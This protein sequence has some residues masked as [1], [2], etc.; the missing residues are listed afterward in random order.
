[1]RTLPRR[2][3][4][5]LLAGLAGVTLVA[6][7]CGGGGG[8]ASTTIPVTTVKTT[9]P[10]PA[11]AQL[12]QIVVQQ[13]DLPSGWTARKASPSANQ[14]ADSAAFAQCVGVSN[15]AG[16]VVAVA[17][18]PDFVNGSSVIASTATSFKSPVDVQTDSAALTNPKASACFVQVVKARLTAALPKGA[19]VKSVSLKITPGAGGG[20]ANVIATASGAIA[21]TANRHTLTLNDDIVFLASPRVEA[22]IDLYSVGSPVSAEVKSAVINKVSTRIATTS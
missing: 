6:S 13:A 9:P 5:R 16:D 10:P 19:T 3:V 11:A 20:P 7:A 12:Q 22:H 21:F 1:M 18:S 4:F 15:T 14:A 2:P 17:Y 8:S